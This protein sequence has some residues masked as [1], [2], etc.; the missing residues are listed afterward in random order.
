MVQMNRLLHLLRTAG[1]VLRL[2]QAGHLAHGRRQHACDQQ[3][4]STYDSDEALI[5]ISDFI[6]Q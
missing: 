6:P 4:G 1:S 2:R 5:H 3:D